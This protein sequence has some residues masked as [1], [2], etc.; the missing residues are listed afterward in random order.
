MRAGEKER[1]LA[2]LGPRNHNWPKNS[3]TARLLN[4]IYIVIRVARSPQS[5]DSIA[6]QINVTHFLDDN[7]D[8]NIPIVTII[9]TENSLVQL[10][11]FFDALSHTISLRE[12]S[13]AAQWIS[14]GSQS[15][16]ALSV[17]VS[18]PGTRTLFTCKQT[19]NN[20]RNFSKHLR[21]FNLR[22]LHFV[23]LLI[24]DKNAAH[25]SLAQAQRHTIWTLFIFTLLRSKS[26]NNHLEWH[27]DTNWFWWTL[28]CEPRRHGIIIKHK[29][30]NH[31]P[32]Q[33]RTL[34]APVLREQDFDW[35]ALDI[36]FSIRFLNW[37]P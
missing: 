26:L 29:P 3:L 32:N 21:I 11:S 14:C 6:H 1:S 16:D 27:S 15:A 33:T 8:N 17:L 4:I 5:I 34:L 22:T 30:P 23:P 10:R 25:W 7:D 37:I 18:T 28:Y 2:S 35:V 31:W 36:H 13:C 19:R 9:L 24:T 12:V 20:H